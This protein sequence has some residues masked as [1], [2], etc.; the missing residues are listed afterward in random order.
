MCCLEQERAG[1]RSQMGAILLLT[2]GGPL[3]KF[4]TALNFSFL[5]YK[6]VG[7]DKISKVPFV[8]KCGSSLLKTN[9]ESTG[10]SPFLRR[11]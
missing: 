8:L 1:M 3:G 7:V 5:T 9:G 10:L 11:V 4:L 6:I 2:S